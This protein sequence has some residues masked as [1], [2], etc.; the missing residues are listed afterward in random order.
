[1]P[2]NLDKYF[3]LYR[4]C[5]MATERDIVKKL[6]EVKPL[7]RSHELTSSGVDRK[8]LKRMTD[9]G[10]LIR[11]ARGLYSAP[12]Y[13]PDSHYTFIEAQKI[14][15]QGVICLLS[16][17]TYHEI[18]TQN[19]SLVWMAIPNRS[20]SPSIETSPIQIV[21]FSGK[22]FDEGITEQAVEGETIRVYNIPK[23]IADCFKYRNKIGLEVAIEALKD[24]IRNK[25]ASVDELLHFADICRVRKI[26]TPYLEGII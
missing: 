19:P 14:V 24:T 13:I 20:W 7:L 23:T 12:N 26:I 10:E 1:V 11:V 15:K 5:G 2:L 21:R 4:L 18:G 6:L 3:Y 25:R 9:S 17:L 8:T 22:A 16:A